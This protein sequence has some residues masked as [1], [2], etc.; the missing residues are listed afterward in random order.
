MQKNTQD[1]KQGADRTGILLPGGESVDWLTGMNEALAYIER[2]LAGDIDLTAAARHA[3]CSAWEFQRHFSFIAQVS[4][5]DH[6]RR[7]RLTLAAEDLQRGGGKVIEVALKYGYDS[8]AAFARAFG[9]WH[10]L[11]PS[12]ARNVGASLRLYPPITF[13]SGSNGRTRT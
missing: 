5:G 12:S 2:N 8:P 3:G 9:Q 6:I 1:A 4:L 11:P 13:E 10:G 7:R